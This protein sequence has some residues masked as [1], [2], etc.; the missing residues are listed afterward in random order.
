MLQHNVMTR[1]R[2]SVMLKHNLLA[3]IFAGYDMK[4]AS[5]GRLF[6]AL[7]LGSVLLNLTGC[8]LGNGGGKRSKLPTATEV[9]QKV[10]GMTKNEVVGFLG[11]PDWTEGP[12]FGVNSSGEWAFYDAATYDGELTDVSVSFQWGV[13]NGVWFGTASGHGV[14]QPGPT[15]IRWKKRSRKGTF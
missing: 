3:D 15:I 9:R 2:K 10:M 12:E 5:S 4:T 8:G 1:V 14:H 11:R 6:C 13:V 7:L